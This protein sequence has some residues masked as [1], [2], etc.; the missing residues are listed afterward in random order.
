MSRLA[1][2]GNGLLSRPEPSDIIDHKLPGAM[3]GRGALMVR[4][5][6]EE[7]CLTVVLAHLALGRNA[8]A[9][10]LDYLADVLSGLKHVL[11]MGDFNTTTRSS[12]LSRFIGQLSL[13]APTE[14]MATYPSWQPQRPIDHVLLSEPLRVADCSVLPL[15]HS[16]HCPVSL[17]LDLA[18]EQQAAWLPQHPMQEA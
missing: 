18:P 12:E 4:Y 14:D 10:Q 3:G 1:Y 2:A 13:Q 6:S 11:L 15:M 9:S 17:T 8:R 16:D 5:G 7:N